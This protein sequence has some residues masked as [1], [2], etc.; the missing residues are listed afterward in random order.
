MDNIF[1]ILVGVAAFGYFIWLLIPSSSPKQD[2]VGELINP[3]DSPQIGLIIGLAGGGIADGRGFVHMNLLETFQRES[4]HRSAEWYQALLP[5][6]LTSLRKE[7]VENGREELY[8]RL[9]GFR[10]DRVSCPEVAAQ[11]GMTEPAVRLAVYH[12]RRRLMQ[13]IRKEA[14]ENPGDDGD[15]GSASLPVPKRPLTPNDSQ[16]A[17]RIPDEDERA[18]SYEGSSGKH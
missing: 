11:L 2:T 17:A 10:D 9:M 7:Y 8:E 3:S 15:S 1:A 6:A 14:G 5:Q 12:F 18:A 4:C 16:G 13:L